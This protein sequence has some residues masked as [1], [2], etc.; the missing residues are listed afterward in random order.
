MHTRGTPF[1]GVQRA[2]GCDF[3]EFGG[4]YYANHFGDPL[5]EH[6]AVRTAIGLWDQSPLPKWE[7]RGE[8]AL[9]AADYV[10]TNRLADLAVGQVKYSPYCTDEGKMM[11]DATIMCFA[12]DRLWLLPTLESDF[13]AIHG[14]VSGFGVE[15]ESVTDQYGVLELQGPRSRE[16]LAPLCDRDL[17]ELGYFRFFPEEIM[18]GGVACLLSRTGYSGE[19]G[20]ELFCRPQKA[21]ALWAAIMEA[22][23]VSPFGLAAVETLRIEAGLLFVG[24][25]YTPAVTS[26]YDLSL[27]RFITLD[28]PNFQ[29]R[30]PLAAEAKSPPRR[31]VT[32]SCESDT[33]PGYGLGIY[34]DGTRVGT[35]TSSCVSPTLGQVIGLGVIDSTHAQLARQVTVMGEDKQIQASVQEL[36]IYDPNKQRPRV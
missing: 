19:L 10:F 13:D 25:D 3:I 15:L 6:H 35:L 27:D 5:A 24:I 33:A 1:D 22:G 28:K 36:P 32:L 4:W 12:P 23:P 16:L 30:E 26:P 7:L 20:Y 8:N 34:A 11:S 17:H 29:G 2:L 21:E 18:V 14:T 31:L 9:A